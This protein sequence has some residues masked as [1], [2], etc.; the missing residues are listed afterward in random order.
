MPRLMKVGPLSSL[1]VKR[2]PH[3]R[4]RVS[5]IV[6]LPSVI[7]WDGGYCGE[8]ER[9]SVGHFC[10]HRPLDTFVNAVRWTLLKRPLGSIDATI[11]S[12]QIKRTANR[13]A[14]L[15]FK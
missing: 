1:R 4:L 6:Y 7:D 11:A 14:P 2:F 13:H 5:L 9:R 3:V 15:S 12:D 8:K 10:K